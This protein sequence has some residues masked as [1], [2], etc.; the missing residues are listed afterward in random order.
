MDPSL[1]SS[2]SQ[3]KTD[4]KAEAP[5]SPEA[6]SRTLN[7]MPFPPW[8]HLTLSGDCTGAYVADTRG[9]ET[10]LRI[11][12]SQVLTLLTLSLSLAHHQPQNA[13]HELLGTSTSRSWQVTAILQTHMLVRAILQKPATAL[14]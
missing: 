10:S 6:E 1:F 2:L 5:T 7:L 13:Q 8:L 3:I 4:P 9:K 14:A 11:T 12:G